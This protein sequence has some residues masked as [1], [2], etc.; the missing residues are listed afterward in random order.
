MAKGSISFTTIVGNIRTNTHHIEVDSSRAV[1]GLNT[2]KHVILAMGINLAAGTVAELVPTPVASGDQ[3]DAFFGVGSQLAEMVRAAKAANSDTEIVAIGI[4]E[5]SG[6]TAG[7]TTATVVG[8]MTEDG[9]IAMY[10]GGTFIAVAVLNSDDQDAIAAAIVV[11]F[12]A[13]ESAARQPFT[14]AATLGV[15]TFTMK[16]KGEDQADV[17]FNYNESDAFPAGITSIVVAEAVAGAG[18]SA[19]SEII[20]AIGDEQYDTFLMPFTDNTNQG[21]LEVELARRFGGMVQ[22]DGVA[23]SGFVGTAGETTTE[24]NARNS[25]HT[26]IMG[27]NESPTSS[28]IWGAVCGAVDAFEPDPARPRQTLP[29]PGLL[30]A[31]KTSIWTQA[32]RNTLLFDGIATHRVDQSGNITVE[33]FVTTYQTNAQGV[34]DTAFLDVTTLRSLAAIRFDRSSAISLSFPRHKLMDDGDDIPVGQP[35]VTP[36]T[37]RAHGIA[38]FQRWQAAGWVEDFEQFV[39]EYIVFIDQAD[40]NRIV[41][42]MGPNLMNQFR[43]LSSQIQFLL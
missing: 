27:A 14:I 35:I 26:V 11:A 6:G 7:T 16:W 8:T 9:T 5:L 4:D 12:N 38:Q 36:N 13:H 23:F 29:L 3:A 28:W 22:L 32:Q 34:P 41:E 1:R 33:R 19:I 40:P 18:N 42:Q 10:V 20:T 24:G 30:P 25:P 17:R 39:D 2:R 31:A 21:L 37:I 43:G 15:V